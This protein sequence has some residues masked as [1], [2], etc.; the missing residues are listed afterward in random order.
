MAKGKSKSETVEVHAEAAQ[1][2]Q[3]AQAQDAQSQ[4]NAG[5]LKE[6]AQIGF[7]NFGLDGILLVAVKNGSIVPFV[8]AK[9][10]TDLIT[11]DFVGTREARKV[12]ENVLTSQISKSAPS[13]AVQE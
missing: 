3:E 8:A 5:T 11:M 13:V 10:V 1:A 9:N 12:I 7:D 4:L 2:A 6:L